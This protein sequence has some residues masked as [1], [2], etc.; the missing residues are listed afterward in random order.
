M[1]QLF[2]KQWA[3]LDELD[4][5]SDADKPFGKFVLRRIDA[6]LK[7]G[8]LRAILE[9]SRAHCP[10]GESELCRLVATRADSSLNDQRR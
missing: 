9:L 2:L 4:R 7:D 3:H 5:L 8:E 6:T 10:T 1:G